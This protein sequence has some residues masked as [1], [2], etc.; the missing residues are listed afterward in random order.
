MLAIANEVE[1]EATAMYAEI[2]RNVDFEGLEKLV[3]IVGML[4]QTKVLIS[5]KVVIWTSYLL[6]LISAI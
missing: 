4:L 5:G 3:K 2:I 1:T 6:I